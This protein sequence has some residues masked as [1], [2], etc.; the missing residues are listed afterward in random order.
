MTTR[1]M[2]L[3]NKISVLRIVLIPV[4]IIGLLQGAPVWP[5]VIFV[6]SAFTDVLDGV[7]A[8]RRGEKTVLGS[9]LDP[10]ADKLLLISTY[11]TLAH[12]RMVPMWVFVVIFARDLLI[13]LGWNIIYIL[14]QNS[15]PAPRWPG[16]VSTFLQMTTV[17]ILLIPFLEP[18]APVF[19]WATVA[20]TVISTLDYIWLGATR[21]NELG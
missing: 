14:T 17:V 20:V 13:F 7:A 15:K 18:I 5:V 10:L 4:V 12:L 21:L 8:R 6:L 16:K 1:A 2:T 3:A 11:L 9:Y 19:L